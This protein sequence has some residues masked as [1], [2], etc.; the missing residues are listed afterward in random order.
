VRVESY[1][2]SGEAFTLQGGKE[3]TPAY[4]LDSIDNFTGITGYFFDAKGKHITPTFYHEDGKVYA[5]VDCFGSGFL[6]YKTTGVIYE[7]SA[8]VENTPPFGG[9]YAS[10]Q[11]ITGKIYAFNPEI[12]TQSAV[13]EIPTLDLAGLNRDT[14][15]VLEVYY[16]T[17]VTAYGVYE[18]PP[19]LSSG[20]NTFPSSI[21]NDSEL[22]KP[23]GFSTEKQPVETVTYR[24][25]SLQSETASTKTHLP[26]FGGSNPDRVYKIAK[27]LPENIEFHDAINQRELELKQKW[28]IA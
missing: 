5:N 12:P 14:G 9:V 7:Y 15:I 11:I 27:N 6:A 23:W 26:F 24:G 2:I 25:V 13:Y 18:M 20:D 17:A 22:P 1:E 16:E 3:I 21:F 10:T 28:G 4:E 8:L 19:N